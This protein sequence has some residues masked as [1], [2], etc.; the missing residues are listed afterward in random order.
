MAG[1]VPAP[2]H[3]EP[4][5]IRE[6]QASPSGASPIVLLKGLRVWYGGQP[7][8]RGM[9]LEVPAGQF[10]LMTGPSGCGKSTLALVLAGLIP[11]VVPA[12]VEGE[13]RVAGLD[14]LQTPVPRLAQHVGLVLQNPAA[15]L[16]NHLV[17]E[18]IAFG[19]RNL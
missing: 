13:A 3:V 5:P 7:A 11:Q 2:V 1:A 9:D 8:L 18:E 10:L 4:M 17:E 19:P 14:V 15:Q 16:F 6:A 12:R